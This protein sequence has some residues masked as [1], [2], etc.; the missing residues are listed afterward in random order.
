MHIAVFG[1]GGVGGYFGGRLAQA[2]EEV[3]FIARGDHLQ[4]MRTH[5]LQVLS[6]KSD[7]VVN[8]VQAVDN[9]NDVGQV[10][11]VI[12]GVKSWQVPEAAETIRPL[13]GDHTAVL[14]LQNGI[15]APQQVADI[16]GYEHV[17]S[18]VCSISASIETPGVIRHAG[19][20]PRINFGE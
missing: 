5:G 8:P 20:E 4:A 19:A 3:V 2:G 18:G 14:T 12:L 9:P 11:F 1:V 17:L 15:E 7:F 6:P 16:L 13:I 10:D